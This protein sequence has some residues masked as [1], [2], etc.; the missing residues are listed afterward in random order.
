[1]AS[2]LEQIGSKVGEELKSLSDRVTTLEGTVPAP[3]G[4]F[5][6]S[7]VTWTNLTEIN[8]SGEKL[9]N[10]DFNLA[11]LGLGV[12]VVVLTSWSNGGK[13][14]Q[15]GE[16]YEIDLVQS[17]G[18]MRLTNSSQSLFASATQMQNNVQPNRPENWT[19]NSSIQLDQNKLSQGIIKGNGGAVSVQQMFNNPIASGTKL[20][21]KVTRADTN[22]N[23]EVRVQTLRA[24]GT[25]YGTTKNIP[26]ADG[27]VEFETTET[28]YGL[29]LST[30]H[31][32]REVS[33]I[34]LFQGAHSGGTVQAN[35]NG[36]LQKIAGVGGWNA[37]ASSSTSLDGNSNGY[38]QFQWG[39]EFKSQRVGFTYLDEDYDA[40]EPFQV[41]I[42]GNGSV[43]TNG[44]N[45]FNQD[46]F[47]EVGD[48]FRIRHYALTNQIHFQKRQ[49]VYSQNPSFVIETASGN[50]YNYPSGQR[51]LVISLDGTGNLTVGEYYEIYTVR[52]SDQAVYLRDLEGNAKGFHG[53]ATRNNR[54]EI[55]EELGE[56][57]VTFHIHSTLTNGNN[58]FVDTSL[59]HVGSQLNDVLFAKEENS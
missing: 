49:K 41:T 30:A 55:V 7:P 35:A 32:T 3:T 56:D 1:M 28:T 42:N 50:N 4:S 54:W 22:E 51:P 23:G 45:N 20:V 48:F 47:A 24:N 36:G 57:Y 46:A 58:L 10:T 6:V 17:N 9:L 29:R 16:V 33:S 14:A 40:I 5:T 31:G 13:T 25:T 53:T 18:G 44:L 15:V 26:Y 19:V 38:V 34:S 21:A 52:A 43:F 37:G 27:F 8:L 39:S 59:Y 11:T 12:E 2:I